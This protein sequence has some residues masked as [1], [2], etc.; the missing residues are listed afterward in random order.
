MVHTKLPKNQPKL[1]SVFKTSLS[2]FFFVKC[3]YC[4]KMTSFQIMPFSLRKNFCC[5]HVDSSHFF[6][7]SSIAKR[8]LNS[9]TA[10]AVGLSLFTILIKI[11]KESAYCLRPKVFLQDLKRHTFCTNNSIPFFLYLTNRIVTLFVHY[12]ISLHG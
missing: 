3:K 7:P 2:K 5:K 6:A 12:C 4:Y 10:Q 11:S 9:P 8:K 1:L